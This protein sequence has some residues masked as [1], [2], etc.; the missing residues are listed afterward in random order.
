MS[1]VMEAIRGGALGREDIA[2]RTG[3]ERTTVDAVIERLEAMGQ[4]TRERLGASCPTTGCGSC[5]SNG[6]CSLQRGPVSLV[7]GRRPV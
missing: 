7:L 4:L 5:S 3:L 2:R 1:Q 6:A